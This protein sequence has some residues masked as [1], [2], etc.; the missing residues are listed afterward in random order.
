LRLWHDEGLSDEPADVTVRLDSAD[1]TQHQEVLSRQPAATALDEQEQSARAWPKRSLARRVSRRSSSP[2][3][4]RR[5]SRRP[6]GDEV[7]RERAG[8]AV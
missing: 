5:D 6:L 4:W 3:S 1:P 8:L 7:Q 2:A